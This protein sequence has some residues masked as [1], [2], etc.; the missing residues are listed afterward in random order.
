MTNNDPRVAFLADRKIPFACFG[1]T[2]PGM[3]QRWVDIDNRRAIRDVTEHVL[4]RGHTRV[5]ISVTTR[6]ADGTSSARLGTAT[7]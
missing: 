3:P 4:A 6:R 5:A 1:R 2:G 7:P